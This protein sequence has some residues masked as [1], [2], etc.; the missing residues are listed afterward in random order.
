MLISPCGHAPLFVALLALGVAGCGSF[1]L[2]DPGRMRTASDAAKLAAD[3]SRATSG[4]FGP[5]EQNLDE[6]QSTQARLRRLS[7][8]HERE[9]FLRI[10]ARLDADRIADRLI[11]AMHDRQE[12]FKALDERQAAAA[13]AVNAALDRQTLI[14][15]H[16]NDR[17]N[18]EAAKDLTETLG[19]VGKRLEWLDN[20]REG[21][22]ALH[23]RP[24]PGA[25]AVPSGAVG[26]AMTKAGQGMADDAA[27]STVLDSARDVLKGVEKDDRVGAA[28]QLVRRAAEQAAAAEQLRLL[29]FR[30]YLADLRRLRERLLVRDVIAVCQ[31]LTPAVSQVRPGT[32]E[33]TT[34]KNRR[35]DLKDKLDALRA[36]GRYKDECDAALTEA[37]SDT[38]LGAG[39]REASK[40]RWTERTLSRYVAASFADFKTLPADRRADTVPTAPRLV[41][42]LGILLFHEGPFLSEARLDVERAL[43]RHSIRLSA[44]NA[45]QRVDL[46]H[47]LTEG[48]EIYHRGGI[49]PE[50]I[51]ELIMMAAR[52][53]ALGFI[54][55]Q[56]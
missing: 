14:V 20:L 53:G 39:A 1:R 10:L 13:T 47:Q 35:K 30:R 43:H 5:M 44:L 55:A 34:T 48:L 16:L 49:K 41:A 11:K 7:E 21:L 37:V 2:H 40:R 17:P 51:A 19:R 26:N 22:A 15:D 23:D 18:T 38:P 42:A 46:V 32:S 4:P 12:I 9:T 52:V 36:S 29:E 50:K 3:L 54:G 28:M 8:A 56:Q 6:V 45:Q 33:P 24:G 27:L 25:K 31:L